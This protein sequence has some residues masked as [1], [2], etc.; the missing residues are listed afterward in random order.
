MVS[1]NHLVRIAMSFE[2]KNLKV[3]NIPGPQGVRG[4]NSNNSLIREKLGWDYTMKLEQGLSRTYFW[5]KEQINL[6][7]FV[8]RPSI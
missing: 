6:Q 7:S 1:I 3:V 5:I 8:E 2:N 4:R